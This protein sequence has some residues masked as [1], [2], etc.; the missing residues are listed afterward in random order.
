MSLTIRPFTPDDYEV[1]V[2]VANAVEPEY[3]SSAD[4]RRFNDEHREPKCRWQ[5]WIA[6]WD[7]QPV[8][9]AEYSQDAAMYH[10][11]KFSVGVNVRPEFE[12]RG[13]GTALHARVLAA[14]EPLDALQVRTATREDRPHALR[15]LQNRGY[16]ES[17]REWESRQDVQ[18]FDFTPYEGYE[19]KLR[20]HGIAIRTLREL[21]TDPDRNRKLHAL[22]NVLGQDVP[23]PDPPTPVEFD[24]WIER[25]L[26]SPKL[27]PD[28][29]F[30]AV[31]GDEYVGYSNLRS[32]STGDF[33]DVDLTGV[34]RE[35]RR[36][37]IA[38][39]L[40]LRATRFARELGVPQV[41]TWNESN[42]AGMLAINIRL[43]FVR[44]P[45][46]V[47]F[48]KHLRPE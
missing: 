6:E 47:E 17:M 30:V 45:A 14:L 48:V 21:E 36:Q 40:K 44:Q 2:S 4:E 23:A 20:E 42:N 26:N 41:R 18:T 8:G 24:S 37:G 25:T 15:F 13:I 33:L 28:G 7:A 29:W 39:G 16:E 1:V 46:W 35:Y 10:P 12:G 9:Y 34:R 43:G 22:R 38:L 11:H 19:E 5:R 31:H 3:P 32:T 27:L